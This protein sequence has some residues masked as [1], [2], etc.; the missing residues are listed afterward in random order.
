LNFFSRS[1]NE[2]KPT[3]QNAAPIRTGRGVK[4]KRQSEVQ[5]ADINGNVNRWMNH[6]LTMNPT[7]DRG[8]VQFLIQAGY[9]NREMSAARKYQKHLASTK[10]KLIIDGRSDG[11]VRKI[12]QRLNELS[13]R[14]R[15]LGGGLNGLVK[16][17]LDQ[18][19][20]T[21][22][23]SSEDILSTK[24]DA[25]LDVDLVPVINIEFKQEN[26][27][28]VPYQKR[29]NGTDAI[30]LDVPTYRYVAGE[31]LEGNP[32]AIPPS[33]SAIND[34]IMNMDIDENVKFILHKMGILGLTIARLALPENFDADDPDSVAQFNTALTNRLADIAENFKDGMLVVADDMD[35]DVHSPTGE[36]RGAVD[37]MDRKREDSFQATGLNPLIV[38]A[39]KNPVQTFAKVIYV[40]EVR[41]IESLQDIVEGVITQTQHCDLALAGIDTTGVKSVLDRNPAFDPLAEAQAR[42]TAM[43]GDMNAM[44]S[45]LVDPDRIAEKYYDAPAFDLSLAY[46]PPGGS[47]PFL[48][49]QRTQQS[50]HVLELK[51]NRFELKMPSVRLNANR[52]IGDPAKPG[53]T[54][55]LTCDCGANLAN[56]EIGDSEVK[57]KSKSER[58][59]EKWVRRYLSDLKPVTD[60]AT[61]K[62]VAAV[63]DFLERSVFQ[64]FVDKEDFAAKSWNVIATAFGSEMGLE[65]TQDVV[66]GI[67]EETYKHYKLAEF[68]AFGGTP[69]AGFTFT[70]TDQ[71][72]LDFIQGVDNFYLG[73]Y[74]DGDQARAS[75]MK[76]LKDEFLDKGA[77]LFDRTKPEV[78]ERFRQA[79]GGSIDHLS[80]RQLQAITDTSVVRM[81]N[82]ARLNQMR[83]AE[84]LSAKWIRVGSADCPICNPF[85]GKVWEIA[86]TL[87]VLDRELE[88][89]PE[90]FAQHIKSQPQRPRSDVDA[91]LSGGEKPPL[92]TNCRC[93]FVVVEFR[94]AA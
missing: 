35:F 28:W 87:A 56:R 45:G 6:T 76:F 90:E 72:T 27:V 50:R 60:E 80:D 44:R 37:I 21:G 78:F 40:T 79:L 11:D 58:D 84:V 64:S 47:Q 32:Y 57:L 43:A 7:V 63:S 52:E 46:T 53:S 20:T 75:G 31:T 13:T 71:R 65:A 62:A 61:R 23:I 5:W 26:G 74:I 8:I 91:A 92:H 18:I 1:R 4:P 24:M 73:K 82:N 94:N 66:D 88:M 19:L 14:I 22:A 38:G 42:T 67:V 29:W 3:G 70:S 93:E 83:E 54:T 86:P 30:R 10:M 36:A 69:P 55:T 2:K 12:A 48:R 81:R 85:D 68:S 51:G 89:S 39:S 25:V 33:L 41:K 9:V 17:Y 16:S 15:P 49:L 59:L 77:D 34:I